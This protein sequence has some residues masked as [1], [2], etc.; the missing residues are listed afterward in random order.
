[1]EFHTVMWASSR[2]VWMN[3]LFFETSATKSL[4]FT[5]YEIITKTITPPETL[6]QLKWQIL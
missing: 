3:E 1:M 4:S 6:L 2:I 5:D